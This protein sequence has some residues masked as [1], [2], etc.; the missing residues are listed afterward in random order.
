MNTALYGA[1]ALVS[2]GWVTMVDEEAIMIIQND[3]VANCLKLGDTYI[4]TQE[5]TYRQT[6]KP[7]RHVQPVYRRLIYSYICM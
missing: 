1:A 7:K 3:N 2:A 4:A 5:T 6:K